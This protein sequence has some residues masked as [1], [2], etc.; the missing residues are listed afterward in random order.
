MKMV[1]DA[2]GMEVVA[3]SYHMWEDPPG[4]VGG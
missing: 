3:I 2:A 1:G 4:V